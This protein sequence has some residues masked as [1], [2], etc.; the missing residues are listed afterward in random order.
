M[1]GGDQCWVGT[2]GDQLS[3]E[4]LGIGGADDRLTDEDDVGAAAGETH[5]VVRSPDSPGRDAYNLRGQNIRDLIEQAAVD[6]ERVRIPGIDSDDTGTRI[7][8]CQCLSAGSGLDNGTHAQGVDSLN[9]PFEHQGLETG[10]E[11][12]QVGREPEP[13]APGTG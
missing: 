8:R 4:L 1:G 10:I 5:D 13:H 6:G 7:D 11:H 2:D 12:E 9:E 3:D